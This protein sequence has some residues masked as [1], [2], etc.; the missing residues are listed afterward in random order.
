MTDSTD[1]AWK[2]PAKA[3]A[4]WHNKES[5]RGRN[6]AGERREGFGGDKG[7][8]VGGVGWVRSLKKVQRKKLEFFVGLLD[9][10]QCVLVS[11]GENS[12][13]A[14]V[15]W[16]D[17]GVEAHQEQSEGS[18]EQIQAHASRSERV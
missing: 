16:P 8:E 17:P 1:G 9:V 14:G 18:S 3:S 6:M 12:G 5:R 13:S 4:L 10:R 2:S 7:R 11:P 15:L